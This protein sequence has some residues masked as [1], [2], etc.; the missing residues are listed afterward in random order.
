MEMIRLRSHIIT[1]TC[2]IPPVMSLA[3]DVLTKQY[4]YQSLAELLCVC[5]LNTV[6]GQCR[7]YYGF[8]TDTW[9]VTTDDYITLCTTI[10]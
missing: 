9:C 8:V 5:T 10:H 7:V 1:Y 6:S 2:F 4:K 3:F